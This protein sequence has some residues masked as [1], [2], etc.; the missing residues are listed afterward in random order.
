M[1][2]V[3]RAFLVLG[4]QVPLSNVVIVSLAQPLGVLRRQDLLQLGEIYIDCSFPTYSRFT[5]YPHSISKYAIHNSS[6]TICSSL[7]WDA[8]PDTGPSSWPGVYY[9]TYSMRDLIVYILSTL[10]L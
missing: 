10:R 9:G 5:F 7:I 3:M 6:P 2:L 1:V 8:C 4:V